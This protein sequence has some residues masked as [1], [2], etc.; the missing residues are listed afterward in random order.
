MSV[1]KRYQQNNLAFS[2]CFMLQNLCKFYYFFL[3]ASM[4]F[5]LTPKLILKFS[6]SET[7]EALNVKKSVTQSEKAVRGGFRHRN[8]AVFCSTQKPA[9]VKIWRQTV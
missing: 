5:P 8:R 3:C 4:Q 1:M 6:K 2:D 7:V 9:P